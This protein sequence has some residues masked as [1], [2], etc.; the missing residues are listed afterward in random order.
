MKT[1]QEKFWNGD[2]G[3]DYIDRN[4]GEIA[5]ASKTSLFSNVL[6]RIGSISS[7]LEFGCNIGLNL[8]AIRRLLPNAGLTGVEINSQTAEL[9]KVG[10]VLKSLKIQF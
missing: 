9:A 7:A 1:E 4:K 6:E 2:F 8:Q 3:T 5:L 10:V